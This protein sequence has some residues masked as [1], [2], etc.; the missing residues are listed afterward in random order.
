MSGRYG[1]EI[2]AASAADAP[3]L[4]ALIGSGGPAIAVR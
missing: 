2:R 1:L 4:A 3:G